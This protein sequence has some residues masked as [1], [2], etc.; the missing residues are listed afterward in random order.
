MNFTSRPYRVICFDLDG[1]L[2]PMDIDE[3]MGSY[4]KSI[5]RFAAAHG[6]DA[7]R[8]MDALKRGTHA[9]AAHDDD[10]T[11]EETFWA[12]FAQCYG[13]GAHEVREL[14]GDFYEHDFAHIGDGFEGNPAVA[15][16]IS[17]LAD[18]GYPLVLTTMPMFPRRAVEHRLQWAGIDAS[19]FARITSYENSK[20]VKP[21][22]T[23]YAE[24]LAAMGAAG[25][26]VLM[27]GNNTQEDL[28]FLDL[29]ADAYLITD[30]LLDPVSFDL[31][32]VKH[33]SMDEF[34]AWVDAL[35][36]CAEPLSNIAT[37]AV[38]RD[39]ME[40]A[41]AANAVCE[42]DLDQARAAAAV[43]AANVTGGHASA[44]TSA[45]AVDEA[46]RERVSAVRG[47]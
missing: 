40:S 25:A 21:R 17:K 16:I 3:F 34:E 37:G 46:A 27:V 14:V 12:T 5:A 13:E 20:S 39:D 38:A 2:L 1:T 32:T 9:M 8:F 42:I 33:G 19:A 45:A 6:L 31:S 26:D 28:A 29:G 18:K 10:A 47:E 24:N 41:L 23:Y 44:S 7:E 36:A 15:R 30:W 4:F 11:N 43:V 22:Q 35:P